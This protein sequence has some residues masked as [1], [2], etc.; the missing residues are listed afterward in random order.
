MHINQRSRMNCDW[1]APYYESLEHLSFGRFLEERRFAFLEKT[2]PSERTLECGGG[3]GRFLARLLSV[4][5]KVQ[6]DFVDSSSKMTELAERRVSRMGS[7]YRER[8]RFFIGDVREFEPHTAGYD[9][10]VT[11]FFLDCFD[12]KELA[13]VVARLASWRKADSRWVVSDFCEGQGMIGQLWTRAVI[14]SLY[15]A[16]LFSTGLRVKRLPD[17]RAI[18]AQEGFLPRFEESALGG[19]LHSSFWEG[20]S[21]RS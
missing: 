13:E 18:L 5:H 4:N 21:A 20:H 19:L 1:L 12:D 9:L 7:V 11:H 6:V 10:I 3:D 8:V 17:Y 14:R 15:A 2:Q 16:F